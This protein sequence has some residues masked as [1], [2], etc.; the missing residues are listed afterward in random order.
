LS[1]IQYDFNEDQ[2]QKIKN[3]YD[4]YVGLANQVGMIPVEPEDL[5]VR[6]FEKYVK[7]LYERFGNRP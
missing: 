7:G 5:I 2:I 1:N 3:M 6:S 4:I